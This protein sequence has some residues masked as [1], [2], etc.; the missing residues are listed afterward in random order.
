M[1]SLLESLRKLQSIEEKLAYVRKKLRT[2]Q[3]AADSQTQKIDQLK[4]DYNIFKEQSLT[5]RKKAD[6]F[7][8]DLKEKDAQVINLREILNTT[9]TNKEYAAV[10]TQMNTIRADNAK[11]E[12]DGLKIIQEI[13]DVKKQVEQIESKISEEESKLE[14]I[15]TKNAEEISKLNR[16]LE[17]LQAQRTDAS[18]GISR[19]TLRMF[20]RL[21]KKYDGEAM[22]EIESHGK[23]PPFTYICGGC[24]MNLNAE[25][26]NALQVSDEIRCCNNCGRILYINNICSESY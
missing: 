18:K 19:E 13:E 15:V 25:H 24:Y 3:R 26:T 1:G 10:L 5:K 21:A 17:K 2:R 9:K 6:E 11:I 23:R 4:Q 20:D 8:L 16:M 7:E 22:A 14:G 12:E